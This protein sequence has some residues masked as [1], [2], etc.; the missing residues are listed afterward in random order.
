MLR[1]A[2]WSL[3]AAYLIAVGIWHS[4]AAPVS[5]VFA[6]LAVLIGLVPAYV[7]ALAAVAIWWRHRRTVVIQP[8]TA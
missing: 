8:V 3:L 6:G 5:L 2:L 1:T 4:A 7:W